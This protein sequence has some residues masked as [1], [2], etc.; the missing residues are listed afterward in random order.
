LTVVPRVHILKC[1][2]HRVV[3]LDRTFQALADRSR[4]TMIDRLTLGPASVSELAEPLEMTLAAVVQ[5]VQVLEGSG[6][7]STEK[8]G[9]VRMCRIRPEAMVEAERWMADHRR[10]WEKRFDRL[11]DVLREQARAPVSEE[12]R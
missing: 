8:V 2:P 10:S 1:M 12:E 6:V 11:G 9:R 5:H 7:V 3:D 4:R